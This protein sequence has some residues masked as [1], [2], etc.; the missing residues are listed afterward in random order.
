VALITRDTN[1]GDG[2]PMTED[3]WTRLLLKHGYAELAESERSKPTPAVS[4][5]P[6]PT[7]SEGTTAR[8]RAYKAKMSQ[9][10]GRPSLADLAYRLTGK[11]TRKP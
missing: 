2:R 6:P 5:T 11:R 3:E 9:T 10:P 1:R 8:T 7:R 4:Q